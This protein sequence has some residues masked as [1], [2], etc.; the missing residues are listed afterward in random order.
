[1][2]N[3]YEFKNQKEKNIREIDFS[4]EDRKIV[5]INLLTLIVNLITFEPGSSS[6]E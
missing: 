2:G 1:M 5:F 6:S 3:Y 4:L